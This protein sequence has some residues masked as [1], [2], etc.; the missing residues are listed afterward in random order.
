M[1]EIVDALRKASSFDA[2]VWTV[3]KAICQACGASRAAVALGDGAGEDAWWLVFEN[4]EDAPACG[5]GSDRHAESRATAQPPGDSLELIFLGR[6]VGM[7]GVWDVHDGSGRRASLAETVRPLDLLLA[8]IVNGLSAT[9]ASAGLL[10]GAGMRTRVRSEMARSR[11]GG[12]PFSLILLTLPDSFRTSPARS[13]AALPDMWEI[14]RRLRGCLRQN[15]AVAVLGPGRLGVVLTPGD[16][17]HASIAQC[18]I[19]RLVSDWC[20]TGDSSQDR[21]NR[22]FRVLTFPADAEAVQEFCATPYVGA[23]AAAEPQ[24]LGVGTVR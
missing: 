3:L 12:E 16:A 17:L 11:R 10:D 2:A 8:M 7:L 13:P 14:A 22:A 21:S 5:G 1:T 9:C 6:Q 18:R 23:D 24:P 15:D 19:E 4:K 20:A